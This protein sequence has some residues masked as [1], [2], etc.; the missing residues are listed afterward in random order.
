M[1]YTAHMSTATIASPRWTVWAYTDR[2]DIPTSTSDPAVLAAFAAEAL[3]SLHVGTVTIEDA[4]NEVA[5]GSWGDSDDI[6]EYL[7]TLT[8]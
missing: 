7:A 1:L 6:D 8:R 4:G 3:R 2:G 5:R